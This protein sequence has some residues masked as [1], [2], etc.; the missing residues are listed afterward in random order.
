MGLSLQSE[1]RARANPFASFGI[2][3]ATLL[4]AS[5]AGAV[6]ELVVS[7]TAPI[8]INDAPAGSVG[9]ASPYPV[10][11]NVSGVASHIVN[12][13]RVRLNGLT[14]SYPDD[15]DV[16]LEGPDGQRA[17]ILSDAGGDGN[18]SG[19]TLTFSPD[20]PGPPP[21]STQLG[22]GTYQSSNFATEGGS[23]SDNFPAPGPGLLIDQS[24]DLTGF[25]GTNPVGAWRLYVV[26]D[27]NLDSGQITGGWS[28]LL[29][30]PD[31]RVVTK[32]ADTNDGVCDA[33]CSLREAIAEADATD[34]IRFGSLFATSQTI[35]LSGSPLLIDKELAIE[36]PGAQQLIVSANHLSR[37]MTVNAGG[38]L[39]LSGITLADGNAGQT[40]SG[41]GISNAGTVTLRNVEISGNTAGLYGGGIANLGI[42]TLEASTVAD[43]LAGSGGGIDNRLIA[44]LEGTTVSGNRADLGGGIYQTVPSATLTLV[45]STIARNA[46]AGSAGGI[47]RD[48][49]MV[50]LESSIVAGNLGTASA[51]PDLFA[52]GNT[53]I[54]SSGYN[55]FGAIGASSGVVT[56]ASD[57][58]GTA[59][60]PL[61]ARLGPLMFAPGPTR[62]HSPLGGSPALDKGRTTAI[63]D[64]RGQPR[65]FD[66]LAIAPAVGGD[67]SDIG[68]VEMQARFVTTIADLGAGSLRSAI[69]TSNELPTLDDIVF[70]GAA[71]AGSATI[72]LQTALPAVAGS[73]TINGS[74]ANRLT[75]RRIGAAQFAVFSR[76]APLSDISMSGL[77]IADGA[78]NGFGGGLST[79]GRE[80]VSLVDI[81]LTGNRAADGGA[82]ALFGRSFIRNCTFSGNAGNTASSRGGA[83]FLDMATEVVRIDDST[84]SGNTATDAGGAIA[85]DGSSIGIAVVDVRNS[86]LAN[87][88]AARGGAIASF[89]FNDGVSRVILR[90]TIVANNAAPTGANLTTVVS[91]GDAAFLSGG[92]NLSNDSAGGFLTQPTDIMS[93][94]VALGVLGTNGGSTPTLALPPGSPAIDKGHRSRSTFDQRGA[95]RPLDQGAIANAA[96]GDGSDIGAFEARVDHIFANGFEP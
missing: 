10:T 91:V 78:T 42:L 67:D 45:D 4:A 64:Q 71:F 38:K 94:P 89:R 21:D 55:L 49:G 12:R 68:A 57:Q 81:H 95:T 34:I 43:N 14:H 69:A 66:I 31:V 28:L 50:T 59:A 47:H 41:G 18:V 63:L 51:S 8:T 60:T 26:D 17:M 74:G 11:V 30:V 13:V 19:L 32:I 83:V 90:N 73:L 37:V 52:V 20:A 1:Q 25:A 79:G 54:S 88:S 9:V 58:A 39:E 46:S 40:Q 44:T 7:N 35:V 2:G 86:T 22:S 5:S 62:S 87:N 36:G 33:D 82:L 93:V 80:M 6:S 70:D 96:G 77:T 92:Y 3:I 76:G 84:F 16:F 53:G 72:G 27:S 85:L 56:T 15:I 65:R 75:V 61:D 29:T 24:A 48:Q 23:V